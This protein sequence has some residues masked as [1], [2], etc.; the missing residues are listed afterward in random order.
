[1]KGGAVKCWGS[2]G[3]GQLGDGS[4][5]D[6]SIPVDVSG[7]EAG[8]S[9]IAAGGGHT[10]AVVSGG[11][12]TCWGSN[13]YQQLGTGGATDSTVPVPVSSLASGVV[14]VAT[15]DIHSCALMTSGG[16]K[17]WGYAGSGGLGTGVP[18]DVP[19]LISRVSAIAASYEQTCA[20]A[21]DGTVMCWG[22]FDGSG[23][24]AVPGL[25][26]G[27]SAISAGFGQTCVLTTNGA[28]KCWGSNGN[29][30]IDVAGLAGGA[31]A[32]AAG[33]SHACALFGTGA[34]TC[35]GDNWDGQ[36]GNGRP[37]SSLTSSSTPVAVDFAR[38]SMGEPTGGPIGLIEHATGPTDVLLRLD[39]GPDLGVGE[40]EGEFFQPGP[41]FTL[42]GDGTVIARHDPEQPPPDEGPIVRSGPFVTTQVDEDEVQSLLR[43]A[44]GEGGLADACDS[45]PT[46]DTDGGGGA[47]L[48]VRAGG[49]ER[50][51]EVAGPSPLGGLMERLGGY[52]SEIG[53]QTQVWVPDRYWGN[54]FEAASAIEIGLLPDPRE[55]GSA[56]WP[57]PDIA[58]ADF[59]GR[60]EGGWI[61]NPRRVMSADEAGVL[62]LSNDG[63]VVRRI[64]LIGPDG[65]TIYSF[66][67]WPISPDEAP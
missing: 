3:G 12:A 23:P 32:I 52:V 45:Y 2:N 54:L 58:P 24:V 17:C 39:Y 65:T 35:W 27:I 37:C 9:M 34:V 28:V 49:I 8:A 30:P 63:G 14:A 62:G 46:R 31:T 1:M 51:V 43:F 19:G 11:G 26:S 18:G 53:A 10:C 22:G 38:S 47:T 55:A 66:S 29:A 67:L 36:L 7:L 6:S 64:Y 48:S 16:V 5:A 33:G 4:T 61:G 21:T 25:E 13:Y 44:L 59:V 41:E 56:P 42:Y 50:R 40:L 57:W 60:D 20:L 15:G